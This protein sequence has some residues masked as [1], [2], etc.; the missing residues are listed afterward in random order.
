MTNSSKTFSTNAIALALLSMTTGNPA[1]ANDIERQITPA[2]STIEITQRVNK[3]RVTIKSRLTIVE[4][5]S[6]YGITAGHSLMFDGDEVSSK[7]L[8]IRLSD[9]TRV[10]AVNHRVEFTESKDI[11]FVYFSEKDQKRIRHLAIKISTEPEE[12]D[13][14]LLAS[15]EREG[16]SISACSPV[17]GKFRISTGGDVSS[18]R[19][20]FAANCDLNQTGAGYSGSALVSVIRGKAYVSGVFFADT[21]G[22][23]NAGFSLLP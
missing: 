2:L 9:G 19:V 23:Y 18:T 8:R 20:D 4:D 1:L 14:F 15:A 5:Q 22:P 21:S 17:N 10:R 7:A 6:V 13:M 3:R 12:S 11:G 16:A